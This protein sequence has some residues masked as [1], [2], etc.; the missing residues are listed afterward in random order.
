[1]TLY[2]EK[3]TNETIDGIE[4][5]NDVNVI[6]YCQN[7]KINKKMIFVVLRKDIETIQLIVFKKDYPDIYDL[8]KDLTLE[9]TIIAKGN[10]IPAQVISCTITKYELFCTYVHIISK[11]QEL[12]FS[13][14]DANESQ[15]KD[16]EDD[17]TD[18][19][20]VGRQKRLENR[21]LDLRTPINRHIFKL[22]SA[23]QGALR[24]QL[25]LDNYEEINTPKIIPGVSEGG[26][27]VF[28][29]NYFGQICFL[30]QSCQ[31]YKQMM[32][33]AGFEKVFEFGAV[34]R[35]ENANTY[36]HLCEFTG[37]DI[38]FVIK[39]EQ[40][41]IEI[42]NCIWNLLSRTF[43]EF[44]KTHLSEIEYVL[45]KTQTEKLIFPKKPVLIDFIQGVEMLKK[46]GIVQDPFEDI[47]TINEK[48]LGQLVKEEY[49]TDMYV[50]VGFPGKVR[51]FYTMQLNESYSR[52]FDFMMRGNEISSGAQRVHDHLILKKQ[53]KERGIILD[54]KSGLEDYVRSFE[55]GAMPHGGCGIGMERMMMLYFGLN[56][57]RTTSLFP[58]DPK[59]TSP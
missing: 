43:D 31:L 45:K 51:P 14:D 27:N 20:N 42:I 54:G 50:L 40:G 5:K 21:W 7:I 9:S 46:Q 32:I 11:A 15:N 52:S 28:E 57:I 33:N 59:R 25:L 41:H 16:T 24:N 55:T 1:M 6:G 38:E 18:R 12:A 53:I 37:F 34:F 49:H 29:V 48:I 36:R 22:K 35:A 2:L 4:N 13:I 26:S 8:L 47:G 39:P 19:C 58:R 10:L 30:A 3:F 44:E 23:L 56:N 17:K